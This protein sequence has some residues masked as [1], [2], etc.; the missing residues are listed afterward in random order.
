MRLVVGVPSPGRSALSATAPASRDLPQNGVPSSVTPMGRHVHQMGESRDRPSTLI[1]SPT[2]C[3][4]L[5]DFLSFSF[6]LLASLLPSLLLYLFHSLVY[7]HMTRATVTYQAAFDD[8]RVTISLY[9]LDDDRR[10]DRLAHL[11]L[12]HPT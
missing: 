8:I 11:H 6:E 4:P 3:L 5:L 1:S 10:L 7:H 12:M 2:C 9:T